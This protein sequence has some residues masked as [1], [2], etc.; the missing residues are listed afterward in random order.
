MAPPATARSHPKGWSAHRRVTAVRSAPD[1]FPRAGCSQHDSSS[2]SQGAADRT[3]GRA[4]QFRPLLRVDLPGQRQP[5]PASPV[6][7]HQE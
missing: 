5:H 1:T 7:Q 4:R 6:V 2:M 3:H